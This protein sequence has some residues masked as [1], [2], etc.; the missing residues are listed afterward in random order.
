MGEPDAEWMSTAAAAAACGVTVRT[1]Y[2]FINAGDLAAFRMGRVIRV[3]R[4][5]LDSFIESCRVQPG[6]LTGLQDAG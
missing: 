3:R 5:D 6:D 1:V 2:G 4:S